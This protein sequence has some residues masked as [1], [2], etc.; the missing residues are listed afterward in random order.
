MKKKEPIGSLFEDV[1][2]PLGLYYFS[3]YSAI[4][5]TLNGLISRARVKWLKPGL[6]IFPDK[7]FKSNF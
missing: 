4:F 3:Y 7:S 2:R 5:T 1:F 6:A